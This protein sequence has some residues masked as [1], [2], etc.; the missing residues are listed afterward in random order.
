MRQLLLVHLVA[1]LLYPSATVMDL[2]IGAALWM[3]AQA[4]GEVIVVP[5]SVTN[6]Q[7]TGRHH[8]DQPSGGT[9]AAVLPAAIHRD[10]SPEQNNHC[11]DTP[12]SDAPVLHTAK[13]AAT[14]AAQHQRS[15]TSMQ[16]ATYAKDNHNPE[17]PSTTARP[18]P[19][20]NSE[21]SQGSRAGVS[22]EQAGTSGCGCVPDSCGWYRSA[23]RVVL[24]GHGA[25]EQHAG[26]G[27]HRTSFRNQVTSLN[28]LSYKQQHAIWPLPQPDLLSRP[29]P[30]ESV[31]TTGINE[32]FQ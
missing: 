15:S 14:Q 24:L 12:T 29:Q 22:P 26:Y 9:A 7:Q 28:L 2:N 3:A 21:S 4:E 19:V 10:D 30:N 5:A 6:S 31:Q 17:P 23:A 13:Q 18:D 20:P 11:S 1:G 27:R 16:Y 32:Q 25:D 8:R